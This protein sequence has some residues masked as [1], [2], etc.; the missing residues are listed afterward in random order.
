MGAMISERKNDSCYV[1]ELPEDSILEEE[2]CFIIADNRLDS[3]PYIL[4]LAGVIDSSMLTGWEY[5]L[6]VQPRTSAEKK[7]NK[8][9]ISLIPTDQ[10][11]GGMLFDCW[12]VMLWNL[13]V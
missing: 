3:Q 8:P 5:N 1:L 9:D 10:R 6:L 4:D 13:K 12:L 11:D 7:S 2:Q